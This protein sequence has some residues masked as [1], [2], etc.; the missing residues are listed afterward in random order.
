MT[1]AQ[2]RRLSD[3]PA[4][5]AE[6]TFL[7]AIAGVVLLMMLAGV[8]LVPEREAGDGS[9]ELRQGWLQ[10]RQ[11]EALAEGQQRPTRY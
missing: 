2:P 6:L 5:P 8:P 11:A 10:E 4:L 1:T 9:E 3:G 7:L